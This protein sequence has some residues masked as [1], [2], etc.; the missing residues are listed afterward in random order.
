MRILFDSKLPQF[1]TPFGCL[2]PGQE[3]TLTIHIPTS[4]QTTAVTCVLTHAHGDIAQLIPL[5]F[6]MKKGPY[7][8]FRGTFC[9]RHGYGR[10]HFRAGTGWPCGRRGRDS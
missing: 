8:H 3:C 2:T 10:T 7:D 1:K 4:V 9:F 5:E 6:S